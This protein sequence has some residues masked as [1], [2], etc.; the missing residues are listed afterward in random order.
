MME[1]THNMSGIS[2]WVDLPNG[3]K[4]EIKWI[5]FICRDQSIIYSHPK[6]ALRSDTIKTWW[7]KRQDEYN[8][9]A[10]P[11]D[12]KV[13][14]GHAFLDYL[15]GYNN[16]LPKLNPV[17]N[18]LCKLLYVDSTDPEKIRHNLIKLG[19]EIAH[20]VNQNQNVY[21]INPETRSINFKL[22]ERFV[23]EIRNHSSVSIKYTLLTI[24]INE[25][26]F[27]VNQYFNIDGD[28][29]KI[30]TQ[31]PHLNESKNGIY[32]SFKYTNCDIAKEIAQQIS[33]FNLYSDQKLDDIED[34]SEIKYNISGYNDMLDKVSMPLK[35]P[36]LD[37]AKLRIND[38]NYVGHLKRAEINKYNSSPSSHTYYFHLYGKFVAF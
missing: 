29:Y 25:T 2:S 1:Y 36:L 20:H 3:H 34:M 10:W 11:L 32:V 24:P 38:Q 4:Q 33:T 26:L 21:D 23:C 16:N 19:Q 15:A 22:P 6:S 17:V 12:C 14:D 18:A 31:T 30:R 8:I 13:E 27:K 37:G 5:P 28:M 9:E 35:I 7:N